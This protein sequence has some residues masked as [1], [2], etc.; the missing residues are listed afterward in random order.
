[1]TTSAIL[2]II[3]ILRWAAGHGRG[4]LAVK[5]KRVKR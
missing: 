1:M 2:E 5:G 3:R 4:P